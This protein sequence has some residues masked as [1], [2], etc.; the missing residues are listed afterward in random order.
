MA[1]RNVLLTHELKAKVADFGLSAQIYVTVTEDNT[2]EEQEWDDLCMIPCRTVAYET[3]F[4]GEAFREKS[5]V[6]S[7]GIFMWEMFHLGMAVPYGDKKDITGVKRYSI[8][9]TFNDAYSL[10]YL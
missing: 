6:W 3:L 10:E 8:L 9:G 7:F 4:R 2:K 5:D 1:A